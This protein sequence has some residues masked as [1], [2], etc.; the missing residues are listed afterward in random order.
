MEL[1]EKRI[2]ANRANSLKSTG[3][4]TPSGKRNSSR[5]AM[6]HGLLAR[7]VLIDGESRE[8]FDELL[9]SIHKEFQAETPTE[10]ALVEKMAVSQWR[11]L[12]LWT[13]ESAG[14]I[15]EMRRQ[16]DS[17]V[18]EDTPTRAMLA[19]RS[20]G[21]NSTHLELINRYEHRFDRQHHRALQALTRLRDQKKRRKSPVTN[22]AT[23]IDETKE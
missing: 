9:I 13:M 23:E 3:P 15:H 1:S 12:R 5:N 6:K 11:L 21:D 2:A 17:M 4:K 16:A 22:Q 18:G 20:L 19:M 14:I 10:C 7:A 8:R